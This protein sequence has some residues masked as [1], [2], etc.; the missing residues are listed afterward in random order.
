MNRSDSG[1]WASNHSDE[2]ERGNY[3]ALS[4]GFLPDIKAKCFQNPAAISSGVL[5]FSFGIIMDL[6]QGLGC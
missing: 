6:Q 5:R 3:P 1:S 4:S 2:I